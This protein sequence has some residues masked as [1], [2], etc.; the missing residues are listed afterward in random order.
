MKI[1]KIMSNDFNKRIVADTLRFWVMALPIMLVAGLWYDKSFYLILIDWWQSASQN[2][3]RFL[4]L[5]SLAVSLNSGA[6]LT[7]IHLGSAGGR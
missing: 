4:I 7:V 3:V 5:F 2:E 6:I 1:M